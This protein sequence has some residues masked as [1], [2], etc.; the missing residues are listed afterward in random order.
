MAQ[1][2]VVQNRLRAAVEHHLSHVANDRAAGQLQGRDGTLLGDDPVRLS[3]LIL[4]TIFQ[5]SL[6]M[7]GTRTS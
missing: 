6:S 4:S 2:L 5:S 1:S 7:T 3:D